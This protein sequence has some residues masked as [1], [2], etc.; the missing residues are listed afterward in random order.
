[1]FAR[2]SF[3]K[4]RRLGLAPPKELPRAAVAGDDFME[5]ERIV[6]A[7]VEHHLVDVIRV[8]DVVQRI[9][10]ENHQI[11]QLARLQRAEVCVHA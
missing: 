6:K 9:A 5:R 2:R 1:M 11:G 7:T 10:V 4:Q 8:A 3:L